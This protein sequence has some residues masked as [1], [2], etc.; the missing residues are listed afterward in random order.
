VFICVIIYLL[1]KIAP[2]ILAD[3]FINLAFDFIQ[4]EILYLF[5]RLLQNE[6]NY[7]SVAHGFAWPQTNSTSTK[8]DP[9][10]L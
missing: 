6:E 10:Y 2:K 8:R 4:S 3:R 9:H 7:I 1:V 5:P